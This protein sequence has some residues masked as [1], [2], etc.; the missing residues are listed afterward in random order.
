MKTDETIQA[1]EADDY[2]WPLM[3]IDSAHYWANTEDTV[4]QSDRFQVKRAAIALSA[5]TIALAAE[6][7]LYREFVAAMENIEVWV[8]GHDYEIKALSNGLQ[9]RIWGHNGYFSS[10]L[11]AYLAIKEF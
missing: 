7:K 8:G 3:E 10:P 4:T 2:E 1:I 9:W 6:L 5:H 11:E